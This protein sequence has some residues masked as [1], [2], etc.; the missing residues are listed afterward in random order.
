M[1]FRKKCCAPSKKS[2]VSCPC[3]C[4]PNKSLTDQCCNIRCIDFFQY[5]APD[6]NLE[7]KVLTEMTNTLSTDGTVLNVATTQYILDLCKRT[8]TFSDIC[9]PSNDMNTI[10]LGLPLIFLKKCFAYRLVLPDISNA[11]SFNYSNYIIVENMNGTV[12][13]VDLQIANGYLNIIIAISDATTVT[14][15]GCQIFLNF[16]KF[17]FELTRSLVFCISNLMCDPITWQYGFSPNVP[18]P[19]TTMAPTTLAPTT[20]AP[21]T[22][23]P[24]TLA[25]TTLVPTT[26]VPTTLAPTTL[27]PT[28]L[29]PTTLAPTT[30]AP[31]TLAPTTLPPTTLPPTTLAPT[32]LA[33]TTEVTTTEAPTTEAPTT[34]A[35]T[36]EAPTTTP[37]GPTTTPGAPTTTVPL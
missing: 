11:T 27:A 19:T 25:P 35:P 15:N 26:L 37:G 32:T 9:C 2:C 4:K 17:N 21:T 12:L 30:L 23:A 1:D 10:I 28:T 36:T 13:P 34:E 8:I 20:L 16:I 14:D 7:F 22:L 31:T 24:T 29:A 6:D 5:I 33:P 18:I 3:S